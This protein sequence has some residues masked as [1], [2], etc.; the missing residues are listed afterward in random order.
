MAVTPPVTPASLRELADRA[1]TL[2]ADVDA[3]HQLLH[4]EEDTEVRRRSFR[5]LG[6]PGTLQR[7]A[8]DLLITA[9]DLARITGR[10]DGACGVAWGVCPEHGNT[11]IP[12]G[13]WTGCFACARTWESDRR[14]LPCP[15][16]IRW[17]VRD[18]H[19]TRQPVCNGHAV[20]ARAQLDGSTVEPLPAAA[21]GEEQ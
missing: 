13:R 6:L 17:M 1:Q 21:P 19:G 20:D 14:S 18:R 10:P 4:D 8:D 15:E 16:P 2:A 12:S 3:T 5:L 9:S 11:L 7:L